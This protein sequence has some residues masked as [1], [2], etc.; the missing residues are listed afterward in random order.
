MCWYLLSLE[1]ISDIN[2]IQALDSCE[3]E[4]N[5]FQ[6]RKYFWNL[7]L[8]LWS[9]NSARINMVCMQPYLLTLSM[10]LHCKVWFDITIKWPCYTRSV[11]EQSYS[12]QH[13]SQIFGFNFITDSAIQSTHVLHSYFPLVFHI[14]R[15]AWILYPINYILSKDD[16]N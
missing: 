8:C 5:K 14:H 2:T 4:S 6:L 13:L 16:Q 10:F 9:L 12:W 15:L 1:P 7:H 3:Q 11:T